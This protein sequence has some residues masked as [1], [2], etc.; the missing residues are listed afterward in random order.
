MSQKLDFCLP[1]LVTNGLSVNLIYSKWYN[2]NTTAHDKS[3]AFFLN[4]TQD[5]SPGKNSRRI[6]F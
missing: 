1:I 4:L 6:Y 5:S 3:I 2:I